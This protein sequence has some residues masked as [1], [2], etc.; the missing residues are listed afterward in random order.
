MA[1]YKIKD[2]EILSGIKAHTIRIWEKRYNILAP[3]RTDTQIRM[4][5]D[6]DLVT[7]LNIC[8]LYKHGVKISHIANLTLNQIQDKVEKIQEENDVEDSYEQLILALLTLDENLFRNTLS[9]LIKEVGL[10]KTFTDHLMPFLGRIGIMWL[11]GSIN[12]AQEHFISNLIRQKIIAE[13]D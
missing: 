10:S 4:Y 12:H 13:I 1:E 3:E 9:T 7:L 8:L 6:K 11:V 5:S 2:L